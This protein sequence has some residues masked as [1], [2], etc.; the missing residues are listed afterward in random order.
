V[1]NVPLRAI[2][3]RVDSELLAN[4]RGKMIGHYTTYF[5]S[6]NKERSQ[7]IRLAA[8]AIDNHVVFPFHLTGLLAIEQRKK[9]ICPHQSLLEESYPKESAA[10]FV[11]CRLPFSMRL[12][13]QD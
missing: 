12:T 1:I 8:A 3:P 2:Y 4:I 9:V 6:Q 11:R 10:A 13:A 7:N 5:N